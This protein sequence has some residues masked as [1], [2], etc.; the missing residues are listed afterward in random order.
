MKADVHVVAESNWEYLTFLTDRDGAR[1]LWALM[2]IHFKL[3]FRS[4]PHGC[5][6]DPETMHP[7]QPEP[8]ATL[9]A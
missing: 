1:I 2:K 7:K 6:L 8:A 4:I 3:T 5:E 9:S